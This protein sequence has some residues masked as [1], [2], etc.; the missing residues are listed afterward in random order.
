MHNLM[1]KK[2][3]SLNYSHYELYFYVSTFLQQISYILS[4]IP[5]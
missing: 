2:C 5:K 4:L 1:R 3:L